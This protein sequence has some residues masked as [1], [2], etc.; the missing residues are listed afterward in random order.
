MGI[1]GQVLQNLFRPAERRFGEDDPFDPRRAPAERFEIMWLVQRCALSVES[2]FAVVE[3]L[4]QVSEKNIAEPAAQNL[5]WQK[6]RT[7]RT[8]YPA[9]A[10]RAE[11]A[12]RHD[13]V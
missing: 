12:S 9:L 5:D 10:V 4:S 7:L 13:A 3:R 1:S 11:S 8:R 2:Q 6:E